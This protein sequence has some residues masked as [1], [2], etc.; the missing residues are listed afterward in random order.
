MIAKY[1]KRHLQIWILLAFI[2][3]ILSVIAYLS[4]PE[5]YSFK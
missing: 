3:L 2:L 4:I 1:R 5:Y